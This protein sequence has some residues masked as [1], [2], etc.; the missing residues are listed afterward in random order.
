MSEEIKNDNLPE[1]A[2]PPQAEAESLSLS[3]GRRTTAFQY[4]VT[5]CAGLVIAFLIAWRWGA[6][7]GIFSA[8]SASEAYKL[9]CDGFFVPGILM[10]LAG[11]LIWISREGAFDGFK[12]ISRYVLYA[13]VPFARGKKTEKYSEYRAKKKA[14]Y[15]KKGPLAF[16]FICG[17]IMLAASVVFWVLYSLA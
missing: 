17:G 7:D 15:K 6:E 10:V 16:M 13:F 5:L 2:N 3:T 8:N 1:A 12:Y 14:E 4:A 11:G 9:L